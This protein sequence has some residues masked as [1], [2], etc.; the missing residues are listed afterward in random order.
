VGLSLQGGGDANKPT[1]VR[2]ITNLPD[3]LNQISPDQEFGSVTSDGAYDTS[4]C[5]DAIAARDAHAL[6]IVLEP[7]AHK[8]RSRRAGMP[9]YGSPI[10]PSKYLGR[11]LW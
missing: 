10:H 11:A 7:M 2:A 5:H 4:K 8:A 9:N 6:T 1:A 3:L